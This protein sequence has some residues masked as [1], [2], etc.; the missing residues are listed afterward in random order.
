MVSSSPASQKPAGS[1]SGWQTGWTQRAHDGLCQGRIRSSVHP[2]LP[3]SSLRSPLSV[4]GQEPSC[5]PSLY[6][7]WWPRSVPRSGEVFEGSAGD[8]GCST[9]QNLALPSV[10]H[11]SSGTRCW[12]VKCL[13]KGL[14]GERMSWG[15]A[16]TLLFLTILTVTPSSDVPVGMTAWLSLCSKDHDFSSPQLRRAKSPTSIP[17]VHCWRRWSPTLPAFISRATDIKKVAFH[18]FSGMETHPLPVITTE[19]FPQTPTSPWLPLG[20]D[21]SAEIK[22]EHFLDTRSIGRYDPSHCWTYPWAPICK[23]HPVLNQISSIRGCGGEKNDGAI[24][25][26]M[27]MRRKEILRK[28]NNLLQINIT[29]WGY[30]YVC[31]LERTYSPLNHC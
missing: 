12:E 30:K 16:V 11:A 1:T 6:K 15:L 5:S 20:R 17:L 21:C 23:S 4:V 10:V 31:L 27:V 13:Y 8:K 22:W 2:A 19:C 26:E 9:L 24:R 18:L 14:Q 29:T 7:W 25:K 3:G 28:Q